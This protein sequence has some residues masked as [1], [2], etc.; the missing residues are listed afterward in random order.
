[1]RA[2][3]QITWGSSCKLTF[4]LLLLYLDLLNQN[5]LVEPQ[6]IGSEKALGGNCDVYPSLKNTSLGKRSL[7]LELEKWGFKS[8]V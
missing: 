4:A 7:I 1:M 5:L 2:V 6:H 3:H 8:G